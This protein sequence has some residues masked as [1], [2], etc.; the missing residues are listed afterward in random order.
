[1]ASLLIFRKENKAIEFVH[2]FL[3]NPPSLFLSHPLRLNTFTLDEEALSKFV[4]LFSVRIKCP[5][6]TPENMEIENSGFK[7]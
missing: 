6:T 3:K 7:N 2:L 5:S 4:G 1:M